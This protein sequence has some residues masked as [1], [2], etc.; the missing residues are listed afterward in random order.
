M[1]CETMDRLLSDKQERLRK[2]STERL[3]GKLTQ[4][5]WEEKKVLALSRSELL[6]AAAEVNW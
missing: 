6:E 4:F 3:R 1:F 2:S 5:D